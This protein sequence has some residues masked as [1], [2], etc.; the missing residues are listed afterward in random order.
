L[1]LA[2]SNRTTFR[3]KLSAEYILHS[4]CTLA[5]QQII[6]CLP[7]SSVV[8]LLFCSY[9]Q[10]HILVLVFVDVL[11]RCVVSLVAKRRS[12]RRPH[13]FG[14]ELAPEPKMNQK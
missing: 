12:N 7:F 3:P 6:S 4:F 11:A 13:R 10:A 8:S 1:R 5:L 14:F 2:I 9:C